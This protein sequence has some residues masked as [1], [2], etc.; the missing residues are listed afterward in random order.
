MSEFGWVYVPIGHWLSSEV[1]FFCLSGDC[2]IAKNCKHYCKYFAKKNFFTAAG[3]LDGRQGIG[4]GRTRWEKG[5]KKVKGGKRDN[6]A[7]GRGM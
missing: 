3:E 4:S 2:K 6:K 1:R 7:G 5:G